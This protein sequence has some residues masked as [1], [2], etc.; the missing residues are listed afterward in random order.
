VDG[1]S[2]SDGS[3]ELHGIP[4]GGFTLRARA[5]DGRRGELPIVVTTDDQDG[6]VVRLE[7]HGRI[8]GRVVDGRGA[9]VAGVQ[10]S[11]RR[12]PP[13]LDVGAQAA[14]GAR[15]GADGR[16]ELLGLD[17]GDWSF[18]VDDPPDELGFL[19]DG[20]PVVTL[21]AGES[22]DGVVLRVESRDGTIRG[23]VVDRAGA[24][25]ADAWVVPHASGAPDSLAGFA[26]SVAERARQAGADEQAPTTELRPAG[27]PVLTDRD[28]R[29]TIEHVLPRDY[30]L[31][32]E[33]AGARAYKRYVK[34]GADVTLRLVPLASLEVR[35]TAAGDGVTDYQLDVTGPIRR[36]QHVVAPDGRFV[37]DHLDPGSYT[38]HVVADGG[39]GRAVVKVAAGEPARVAIAL[40]G[41]GEVS[42]T[43]VDALTGRT[44]PGVHLIAGNPG[45]PLRGA[46]A[47]GLMAS[48]L[49]T[50]DAQGHFVIGDVAAGPVELFIFMAPQEK[51]LITKR[52]L[53]LGAGEKKDLGRVRVLT[54][55]EVE[56]A[57]RGD[58]GFAADPTLRVVAVAAAGPAATA[59][60]LVDDRVVAID[61]HDVVDLGDEV[62]LDLLQT[63]RVR[64]G[65]PVRLEIMRAG[66]RVA[67]VIQ[68]RPF[69]G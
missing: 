34:P 7:S 53:E 15:T 65:Q 8:A 1:Q 43:L 50:S 25:V 68:A 52:T 61:G 38:L 36:A 6:L 63:W 17:A 24:P 67:I 30:D 19:G 21:A 27:R 28:G 47:R 56:A 22:K 5:G 49:P 11:P 23:R 54:S 31:T 57:D 39:E 3:F 26:A 20:S 44:L 18:E 55:K 59:G 42:G 37:L 40:T 51:D 29:F 46:Q 14:S 10:V 9:P 69:K 33:A 2:G 13:M 45:Q 58:L 60:L 16:F 48:E 41:W 32:A 62:A 35:V 66:R 64:A 12:E 4:A